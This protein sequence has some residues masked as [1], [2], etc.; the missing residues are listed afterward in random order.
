MFGCSALVLL[1]LL[2]EIVNDTRWSFAFA[3]MRRGEGWVGS[4]DGSMAEHVGDSTW[5]HDVSGVARYVSCQVV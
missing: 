4:T 5:S 1:L 2:C 3:C